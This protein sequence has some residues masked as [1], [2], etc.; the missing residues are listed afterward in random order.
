MVHGSIKD[1]ISKIVE[2]YQNLVWE[3]NISKENRLKS[4]IVILEN[5]KGEILGVSRKDNSEDFGLIGGSLE[6]GETPEQ[7]I[8]RES[9]EEADVDILDLKLIYEG[10][11]SIDSYCYVFTGKC[12]NQPSQQEGEGILKWCTWDELIEGSFGKFNIIVST[13]YLKYKKSLE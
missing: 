7:C 3:T 2:E 4:S 6:E 1:Q 5:D 11:D 12:L 10:N 8:I 13:E 9:L